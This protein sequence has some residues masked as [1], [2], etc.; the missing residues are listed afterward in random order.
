M[1]KPVRSAWVPDGASRFTDR[2]VGCKVTA[3]F[4]CYNHGAAVEWHEDGEHTARAGEY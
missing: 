1:R 4:L 2:K 3:H